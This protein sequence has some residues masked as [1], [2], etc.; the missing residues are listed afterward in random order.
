MAKLHVTQWLVGSL[1][2][3]AA[4]LLAKDAYTISLINLVAIAALA[5]ASL[6]FVMLI[7]E[8]S[9]T[10]AAFVGIGAYSA[11]VATT[12][13]HWPFPVA[14]IIGPILVTGVSII[15]GLI[16][17]RVKGPY[18]ML[19]SF[20]FA[21]V[22]RILFTKTLFIGG[23][24]G[25]TGIFPPRFMDPWMPT[26]VMAVVAIVLF[27]LYA[28]EKSDFGKVLMAIRDNENIAKT[29]GINVLYNKVA[30]LAIS[31]FCAGIVGSLQAFVNNVIS[32]GDF[33]YLLAVFAL[34]YVKVGGERSIFG[35]IMGAVLLVLLGS[36]A[37]GLGAGEQLFYGGAI[38]I[39]VL[40]M[41]NGIYGM[42]EQ[43]YKKYRLARA[44]AVTKGAVK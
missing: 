9:M 7:G 2:I 16:T 35:A 28:I 11:G 29:V 22:A 17:L 43:R 36:Y 20:A 6:R 3:V 12:I 18:F 4:T 5:A 15:F 26:F 32:P 34:A 44:I 40:L 42:L 14:L 24:S 10:I 31:S 33:S 25:M 8:V 19:I 41:P 38:V 37:L 23:T 39:A 30:C 21:E 27:G 1:A 13:L